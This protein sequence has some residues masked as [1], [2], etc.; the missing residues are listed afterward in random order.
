MN[1][2]PDLSHAISSRNGWA[3]QFVFASN[4]KVEL[5]LEFRNLMLMVAPIRGRMQEQVMSGSVEFRGFVPGGSPQ[6]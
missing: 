5:F 6:L 2:S 4:A 3:N 1:P